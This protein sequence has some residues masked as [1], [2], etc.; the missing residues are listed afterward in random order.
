VAFYEY[1]LKGCYCTPCRRRAK[2][3]RQPIEVSRVVPLLSIGSR[4]ARDI[5]L[6][7]AGRKRTL[8]IFL[9][10]ASSMLLR[11]TVHRFHRLR[12]RRAAL[13]RERVCKQQQAVARSH[14]SAPRSFGRDGLAFD[15]PQGWVPGL[16]KGYR[17]GRAASR[18]ASSGGM[19][20]SLIYLSTCAYVSC[21]PSQLPLATPRF[22]RRVQL[23]GDADL[24]IHDSLTNA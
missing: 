3:R 6:A 18:A 16:W 2:R 5:C 19:N 15:S 9:S 13:P 14:Q 10:P 1:R 11:A 21:N 23:D 12:A 20:V 4:N 7:S 8:I 17:Q 24:R 22:G